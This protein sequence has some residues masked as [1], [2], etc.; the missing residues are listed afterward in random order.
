MTAQLPPHIPKLIARNRSVRN[1]HFPYEDREWLR[2]RYESGLTFQEI[3]D[4]AGCG[5]R[6]IARW[7]H[8]HGLE[9]RPIGYRRSH[10]RRP[11]NPPRCAC[12]AEKS[13]KGKGCRACYDKRGAG[14]PN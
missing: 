10:K 9:S 14:N 4:E 12:G 13:Y 6:T 3:A 11:R 1:G 5:L 2:S 7:F 8:A